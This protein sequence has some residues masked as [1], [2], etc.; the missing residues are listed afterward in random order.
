M[1][2]EE[3]TTQTTTEKNEKTLSFGKWTKIKFELQTFISIVCF[4]F[5]LGIMWNNLSNTQTRIIAKLD[6]VA[7]L[8]QQMITKRDTDHKV[9]DEQFAWVTPMLHTVAKKLWLEQ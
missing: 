1:W 5:A 6:T 9:I 3:T 8:Q 2:A 4:V 7:S